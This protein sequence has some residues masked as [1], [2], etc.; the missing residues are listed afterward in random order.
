MVSTP[1][2]DGVIAGIKVI[3]ELTPAKA[4][5]FIVQRDSPQR[6][7]IE[8]SLIVFI[9]WLVLIRRTVDSKKAA[10]T[11]K[12]AKV[13][14]GC[15]QSVY[16]LAENCHG[17]IRDGNSEDGVS[18]IGQTPH[19]RFQIVFVEE[20]QAENFESQVAR[21]PLNYRKRPMVDTSEV[22]PDIEVELS[23]IEKVISNVDLRRI[24]VANYQKIADGNYASTDYDAFSTSRTSVVEV[25]METKLR[26]LDREDGFSLF[27]QKPQKCHLISQSKYKDD[28][29]NPNNI[30]FMSCN[31]HQQFNAIDSSEGIPM[32]YLQYI[33]HDPTP[34]MGVVSEKPCQVYETTI[35][36]VFKDEEAAGV[37]GPAFIAHTALS[38]TRIQLK[39]YFPDPLQFKNYAAL[40]A[41]VKIAQWRSYDGTLE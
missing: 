36:V 39:L 37:L 9:L 1:F 32:F 4:W 6:I 19:L 31:L 27:R 34:I 38:T 11:I 35:D 24:K 41:E 12:F 16:E 20:V 13:R 40:N 22:A 8:T 15:Q 7:L 3:H 26:L 2:I 5:D 21:I 28:K 25:S 18:Y 23:S 30:L 10:G 17:K 29:N 14:A 33:S